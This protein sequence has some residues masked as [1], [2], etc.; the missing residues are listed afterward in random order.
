MF[1]SGEREEVELM[2]SGVQKLN[3]DSEP[4]S[5]GSIQSPGKHFVC[6]FVYFHLSQ[7][8]TAGCC[9]VYVIVWH[10][11]TSVIPA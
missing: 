5:L 3:K 7:L 10:S 4:I 6:L 1:F 2:N 9:A 11:F 8:T